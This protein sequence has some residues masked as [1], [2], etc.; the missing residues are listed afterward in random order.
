MDYV[1]HTTMRVNSNKKWYFDVACSRHITG[2]SQFLTDIKF[3][4]SEVV[5]FGDGAQGSVLGKRNLEC[6]RNS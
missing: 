4:G 5:A 3:S 6:T 2:V 1:S